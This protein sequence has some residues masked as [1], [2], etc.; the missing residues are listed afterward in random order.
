MLELDSLYHERIEIFQKSQ[1]AD[2]RGFSG[3]VKSDSDKMAPARLLARRGLHA[4]PVKLMFP[5]L[6]VYISFRKTDRQ[7]SFNDLCHKMGS[8]KP[9]NGIIGLA[10]FPSINRATTNPRLVAIDNV[11]I[12]M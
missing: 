8:L 7:K 1:D 9:T 2:E 6:S 4:I 10:G 3:D 11:I 5:F 12:F